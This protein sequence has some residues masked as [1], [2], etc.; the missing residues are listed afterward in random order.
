MENQIA[1]CIS[2]KFYV[3]QLLI[4]LLG[5]IVWPGKAL[6][7]QTQV[8]FDEIIV[9]LSGQSIGTAEIPALIIGQDVYL[10]VTDLFNFLTIK[11]SLSASGYAITGF[12]ANPT[13]GYSINRI[14]NQIYY[15]DSVTK[16]NANDLIFSSNEFYLNAKYFGQS[17]GLE[18]VFN[19]RSLTVNF[20]TK[21]ELPFMREKRL[22]QMRRNITKLKGE[23]KPDTIVQRKMQILHLGAMDWNI[24]STR[25]KG[26]NNTVARLNLGGILAGGEATAQLLFSN[27]VPFDFKNQSFIWRYV[28]NEKKYF[29][30]VSLG[31]VNAPGAFSAVP[32]LLGMQVNN[33]PTRQRRSF[34]SYMVSDITAPGWT[35]ELYVNEVLIDYTKADASGLFSFEVPLVY[36]NT[37]V[38]FKFYGPWGEERLSE[39]L[40]N[41]P[42]AFLPKN[43]F[44]YSFTAGKI[45]DSSQHNF[46]RL[47]FNYGINKRLTL[48]AGTE[49]N[50]E[51]INRKVLPFANASARLGKSLI[52]FAEYA[53]G[54]MFKGTGNIRFKNKL[55]LEAL[56]IQYAPG[57]EAIRTGSTQERKLLASIPFKTKKIVGFSRLMINHSKFYKGELKT[58]ELLTSATKGRINANVTTYAVLFKKPEIMSRLALNIPLPFQVR[59]TPQVQYNYREQNIV[60]IKAEAEKRAFRNMVATVG[61]EYNKLAGFSGFSLGLRHNFSFAQVGFSARQIGANVSVTQTASGGLLFGGDP[62]KIAATDRGNVGQGSILIKP[63]LDINYNGRRDANEPDVLN[64]NVRVDG[65]KIERSYDKAAIKI[66][67]LE[68]YNKYYLLL[69]DKN[70]ENPAYRIKHKVIEIMAEPNM[71]KQ[72]S[73][74]VF[75]VGE[76]GGYVSLTS[77]Q[78]TTGIGRLIVNIFD[79]F[80]NLVAKTITEDDGYFSYLGLLPGTYTAYTDAA[81]LAR[82][83]MHNSGKPVVFTI[84][85]NKEGDIV[86][87]LS[88]VVQHNEK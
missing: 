65:C 64:L 69:D 17:F 29:K 67:A 84:K 70:F 43:K 82:I 11:N 66:A 10:P 37:N 40:I 18:C 47:H 12:L 38:K 9:T 81:Q 27:K 49:Y 13:D 58:A 41:I 31:R 88:L 46:S 5:T 35:V 19:F 23:V 7:Q 8:T 85:A 73:V 76:A 55:Q 53:P 45:A 77:D 14:D 61:Y 32:S 4:L 80:Q 54:T 86:E 3:T 2:R 57:Q 39:Q 33:S 15:K 75:V 50:A 30:Q 60:L 72:L 83:G 48:G 56:F 25:F 24:A 22:E 44:D 59:F 51:F 68:P 74:P 62:K 42:F 36:G 20:S 21:I 34:G 87:N 26:D 6:A 71:V 1:F 28:N 79:E 16:L 78:Q 52:V 63:F